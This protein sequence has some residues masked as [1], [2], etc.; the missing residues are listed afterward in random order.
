AIRSLAASR[1]AQSCS[2]DGAPL[3]HDRRKI[4]RDSVRWSETTIPV[5]ADARPSRATSHETIPGRGPSLFDVAAQELPKGWVAEGAGDS[6]AAVHRASGLRC[7]ATV[8]LEYENQKLSFRLSTLRNFD[9]DALDVGCSLVSDASVITLYASYW[10]DM[11]LEAHA[12]AAAS[13]I[14]QTTPLGKPVPFP[15]AQPSDSAEIDIKA[16]AW[17]IAPRD[18]TPMATAL[19]IAKAFGWHVKARATYAQADQTTPVLAAVMLADNYQRVVDANK[20]KGTVGAV[21]SEG[22]SSRD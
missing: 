19:W 13:S 18:G 14:N 22:E 4:G 11:S 9:E 3:G 10:P 17:E 20:G 1:A 16:G 21:N 2:R 15:V 8:N 12:N 5:R 7:P 6:L